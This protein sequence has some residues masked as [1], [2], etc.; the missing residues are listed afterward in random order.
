MRFRPPGLLLLAALVLGLF[1]CSKHEAPLTAPSRDAV[2]QPARL[3]AKP[4]GA[5]T[6]PDAYVVVFNDAVGDVDREVDAISQQYGIRASFRYRYAIKGFAATMPP[7]AV[8]ALRN[9]P[10][11]AYIEQDQIAHADVT[12]N[13]PT[14]GIDRIDQR[15]LP[16]SN[17]YTYDQTGA[18]LDAYIIDTGIRF[19]HVEFGGRA[20]TGFDAINTGG[21]ALDDNGHGTHVAGTV[22]GTTYGVAKNVRLIAVKVLDAG[23]SGSFSQVIAGVDWV[24]GDH[25]TTPAAANMSLSGGVFTALNDAVRNSI[26]DGVTYCVAAG[27]NAADASTRSPASTVEAIT[28]AASDINDGWA[29]FSNFGSVVDIIAPGVS[30]T[31]SWNTSDVATNTISG[32]SMAT[33]HTCGTAI[34]YLSANPGAS[35]AAVSSALTSNATPGAITGVPA[36]TANLLLYS[37]FGAPPPPGLTAPTLVSPGDGANVS[38]NPT[39]TWNTVTGATSYRVQVSLS[40][41]FGTTAFDQVVAGTSVG[42]TGLAGKTTYFWRVNASNATETSPWSAVRSFKTRRNN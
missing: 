6:V 22:G 1:G 15:N 17:S 26:N 24:T 11:V 33:P 19:T 41:T 29:S 25:T 39:L 9:N 4:P 37:L 3:F 36:G 16:L 30:V 10:N 35:P 27:N 38:R 20:V 31:S 21:T 40:S 7:A 23:G 5:N 13:N 34:L 32:T 2:S 42:V 18:G 28:V 12:Q 14:W 8:E